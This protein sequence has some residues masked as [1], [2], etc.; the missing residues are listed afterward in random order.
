M[1]DCHERGLK[2]GAFKAA[3]FFYILLEEAVEFVERM[4]ERYGDFRHGFD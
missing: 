1:V 2:D 4:I 3:A